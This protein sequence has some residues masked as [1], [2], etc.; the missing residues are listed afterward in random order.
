MVTGSDRA[1]RLGQVAGNVGGRHHQGDLA[2][3]QRQG[4]LDRVSAVGVGDRLRSTG[5]VGL[6][7]ASAW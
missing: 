5:P 2:V 1:G 7:L 3:V 6:P 4:Q